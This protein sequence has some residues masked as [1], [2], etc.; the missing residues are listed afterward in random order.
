MIDHAETR[1]WADNH[2]SYSNRAAPLLRALWV[3]FR[4]LHARRFEA[5]WD[6]PQRRN[7]ARR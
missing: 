6:E 1:L 4:A 7:G 2:H 5:P 3:A